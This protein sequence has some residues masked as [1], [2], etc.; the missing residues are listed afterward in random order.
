MSYKIERFP[1][2]QEEITRVMDRFY[3]RIRRHAVLGPVFAAHVG[4][5][6]ADWD[7][8]IAKIDGFWARALL[9]TEGYD[10][11]PM[12]AH[13]G[14]PLIK[15]DHFPIWLDLFEGTLA[16]ELPPEVAV[17][18]G[19]MAHRIARGFRMAMGDRDA[20]MPVLR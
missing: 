16:A 3:A 17:A 4:E 19:A 5:T 1:V 15:L 6:D 10:G 8:H 14:N 11:N 7:R 2:T 13:V 9:G 20:G 12:A 18:W